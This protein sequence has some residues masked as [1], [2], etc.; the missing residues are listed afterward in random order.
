MR[1][2]FKFVPKGTYVYYHL[3][4]SLTLSTKILVDKIENI[5]S[6]FI[7]IPTTS[8]IPVR[9]YI[10]EKKKI[11]IDNLHI[12][13]TRNIEEYI[14]YNDVNEIKIN[15]NI[16]VDFNNIEN[17]NLTYFHGILYGA[18]LSSLKMTD[19]ILCYYHEKNKYLIDSAIHAL[20][21]I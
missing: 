21:N 4:D 3:A 20:Q 19:K 7:N 1:D 10:N 5:K 14:T 16:I 6:E 9:F 8:G 18:Y 11:P 17:P 2:N 15:K 13:K 12:L